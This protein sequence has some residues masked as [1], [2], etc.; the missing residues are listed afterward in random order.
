[1]SRHRMTDFEERDYYPPPRRSEPEFQER[2][3]VVTRSP[4]PRFRES[5]PAFLHETARRPEAGPMVLRQR[6]V[7]TFDRHHRSPSPTR[8]REERLLRRPR[9][10]SPPRRF[11]AEP[12]VDHRTRTRV[13]HRERARSP[14]IERR[15]RSPSPRPIRY[16][17]EQSREGERIRARVVERRRSLSS[18]SSSSSSA[19]SAPKNI[20][21]P[22]IEREVITHYTDVDHGM[23]SNLML[24]S[25]NDLL[26][27][28]L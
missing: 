17:R 9:S 4:P 11:Y 8:L 21:G 12:E 16:E 15:R 3:R 6:E 2:R 20:R 28:T 26:Q 14:S 7:E 10:V 19:S 13:V 23:R 22:T 27:L 1:M 24:L 18:S 5:A 25:E